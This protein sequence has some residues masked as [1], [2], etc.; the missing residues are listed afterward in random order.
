MVNGKSTWKIPAIMALKMIIYENVKS[1][2]YNLFYFLR[3]L[4]IFLEKFNVFS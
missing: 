1:Y 2:I 4:K 3:F